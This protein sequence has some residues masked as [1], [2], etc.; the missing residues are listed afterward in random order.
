[1]DVSTREFLERRGFSSD[2]FRTFA[3]PFFG[4]V[5]A[6]KALFTSAWQFCFLYGV[7]SKGPAVLPAG[8]IEAI[9]RAVAAPLDGYRISTYAPV[10]RIEPGKVTLAS[11]ESIA[12]SAVVLACDPVTTARF[13]GEIPPKGNT[14]TTFWYAVPEPLVKGPFLVLNGTGKGLVNSVAPITNAQPAYAPSG[15][16]LLSASVLTSDPLDESSVRAELQTWFPEGRV[17]D[18]ELLRTD[19]IPYAQTVQ[20]AGFREHRPSVRTEMPGIFRAG[21]A[22]ENASIDGAL[23]SGLRAAE[24]AMRQV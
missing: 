23:Q 1:M 12:A 14:S 21:E 16:H 17:D 3:E 20:P 8:G 22:T 19:L 18:W 4:G 9:A 13:L 24:E 10:E 11:G 7:L 6:E 15:R 5:F 2:W